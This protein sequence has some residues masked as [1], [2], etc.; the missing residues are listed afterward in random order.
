MLTSN[1]IFVFQDLDINTCGLEDLQFTSIFSV[2]VSQTGN[3]TALIGFFD[4]IFD[5]NC[6]TKVFYTQ[7][8]IIFFLYFYA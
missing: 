4:I 7:Q 3:V 2:K 8:F 5:M 6:L 1:S